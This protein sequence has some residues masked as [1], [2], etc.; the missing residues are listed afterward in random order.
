MDR[1]LELD[2]DSLGTG[3]DRDRIFEVVGR[4]A[5]TWRETSGDDV[6]GLVL[7]IGWLMDPVLLWSGNG[8]QRLP[9]RS[10][11]LSGWAQ[12]SY[13]TLRDTVTEVRAAA[14]AHGVPHLRM[15]ILV[16]GIGEFV[17]EIVR[18]PGDST[19]ES[20]DGALYQER[21]EWIKRQPQL[22]PFSPAV[23]LHGPGLDWRKSLRADPQVLASRP[24]GVHDG[25]SFGELFADQWASFSAFLGLD[26]LLLRDETTTP[27]HSG[28]I[29]FDGGTATATPE[30][31]TEWT[32]SLIASTQAI[33]RAS[34]D[35][36]LC[37]Y[38]S[39]LS[40][41]VEARFGRLD[42]VRVVAEGNIDAWVDQTWGGAWQDWWDAGW[43]G[44]TFQLSN[45]LARAAL[46]AEGNLRR[47]GNE[48]RHYP[49][50][51]LLDGW[52]PYDTLHDYP[53]KLTWGIWAFTHAVVAVGG[54]HRP[55]SGH[56]LAVGNDRT[57]ALIS[58]D[59]L[60]TVV[61]QINA[62]IRS[63]QKLEY[64]LGPVLHAATA[65]ELQQYS[66]STEPTEDAV[67]F[68]LKWG[69]PVITSTTTALAAH[70]NDESLI[71]GPSSVDNA[72]GSPGSLVVSAPN[73]LQHS[74][75]SALGLRVIP[76]S[77]P[78]GYRRGIS[79]STHGGVRAHAWPYLPVH[80]VTV[81]DGGSDI[82]YDSD[83]GPLAVANIDSVLWWF[84]PTIA[85]GAD[86]RMTHYQIGTADPHYSVAR[87]L[88]E[89]HSSQ[90]KLALAGLQVHETVSM[91]G[92]VSA[93]TVY[94]LIG[95]VESGWLGD[96]RHP[97]T[98]H[99]VLP[100][101]ALIGM[102][103]PTLVAESGERFEITDGVAVVR[104]PPES[105]LVLA[106]RTASPS[107]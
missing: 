6:S 58:P 99:V 73:D 76:E 51:Q 14:A 29:D 86:R 70:Q 41:T 60:N 69:L 5:V 105:C 95:N 80:D 25:D 56:Y 67:G 27:V 44:W 62:A 45:L 83:D 28:R 59:D 43:Q 26:L 38:S 17:N 31:V 54:R 40:P 74:A 64:P 13:K 55:V 4:L 49:I 30:Q 15:G 97:R 102:Q 9:L 106:L 35:T 32:D 8:D 82:I 47:V 92:W 36:W 34:P 88:S 1:L 18:A 78:V 81:P 84:P 101:E 10:Q 68:L 96:S 57:G 71:V 63:V 89:I 11:R 39:G 16:L 87:S 50:V 2:I 23:T 7:N 53:H 21:G 85:N 94:L 77:V 104:V 100:R 46:I 66:A 3:V 48:C 61:G 90:G 75:A 20:L 24:D 103:T 42:I 93:G 107:A 19:D 79:P 65:T 37:L 72:L 52:E 98:V 12:Q 91:H 22:Y 33:K